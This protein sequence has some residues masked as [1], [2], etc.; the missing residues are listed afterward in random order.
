MFVRA[1]L[2]RLRWC[3]Y[4][5]CVLNF[6]TAERGVAL[7]I[8]GVSHRWHGQG[9]VVQRRYRRASVNHDQKILRMLLSGLYERNHAQA[10][11][12]NCTARKFMNKDPTDVSRT[13]GFS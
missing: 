9:N 1:G 8:F 2:V 12:K 11:S 6:L 5:A 7:A 13:T 10:R 4:V 3:V